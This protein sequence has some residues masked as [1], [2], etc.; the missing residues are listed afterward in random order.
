MALEMRAAEA[1]FADVAM[2][3]QF[4]PPGPPRA[5]EGDLADASAGQRA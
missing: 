2:L 3:R 4:V 1:D 5:D